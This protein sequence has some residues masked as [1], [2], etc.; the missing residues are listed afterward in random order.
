M[1]DSKLASRRW[2]C[3]IALAALVVALRTFGLQHWSLDLDESIQVVF[4]KQSLV[5]CW[6]AIVNDGVHPPL[7]YLVTFVVLRLNS[8]DV[9]LRTPALMW[10]ALT[11]AALWIRIGV[12]RAAAIGAGA[13]FAVLPIAIHYGQEVRPYALAVFLIAAADAVRQRHAERPRT[14]NF[15]AYLV[16]AILATYTHY[17]A[18]VFLQAV[19]L[20]ELFVAFRRRREAPARWRAAWIAPAVTALAFVPW[21]WVIHARMTQPWEAR[22]E[23]VSWDLARSYLIGFATDWRPG[24]AYPMAAG[25]V[26]TVVLFGI[27]R[28]RGEERLRLV[29]E[30]G[31][32]TVGVFALLSAT[33]H[34][35]DLRYGLFAVLPFARALG[36]AIGW[37]ASRF[38]FRA[39]TLVASCLALAGVEAPGIRENVAHGRPDW[40]QPFDYLLGQLRAG[41]AGSV[42]AADPWSLNCLRGQALRR[43]PTFA[44]DRLESDPSALKA[45]LV[46]E[47]SG[48]VVHTP[49]WKGSDDLETFLS[50][51]PPWASFPE[52]E[53]VSV[54]R[55]EQGRFTSPVDMDAGSVLREG[56]LPG[57]DCWLPAAVHAQGEDGIRWRTDLAI[58]NPSGAAARVAL[59]I[60]SVAGRGDSILDVRPSHQIVLPDVG[61]SLMKLDGAWPL[62]VTAN[63]PV[64]VSARTYALSDH[65]THGA[66]IP[67][68]VTGLTL[69]EG[70][71]ALLPGLIQGVRYR[72]NIGVANISRVSVRVR[73]DLLSG[74]GVLLGSYERRVGPGEWNQEV[75]PFEKAGFSIPDGFAR[76]TV[77]EGRGVF[78][79]ASVIDNQTGDPTFLVGQP[80]SPAGPSTA[81]RRRGLF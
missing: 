31:V 9:A 12:N 35:W 13:A 38:R 68:L 74:S 57:I 63:V 24:T 30:L 15:V 79:A 11:L 62:H 54:L 34:W 42:I 25:V 70:Q 17:F 7:D 19:F 32:S 71:S 3:L 60:W 50:T 49:A 58:L 45:M 59:G 80:V 41:K 51:M 69:I 21:L 37:A 65:G 48:W 44:V 36:E 6:K 40:R 27:L 29:L 67:C 8:A 81:T 55:F 46:R 18:L 20:A 2:L 16:L 56:S 10:S 26:W 66:S 52:S 75:E 1:N 77:E 47:G 23:P 53:S 73:V 61:G 72:T 28:A 14:W 33:H 64:E 4:A 43:H 22:P 39:V 5:A 78:A 76:V